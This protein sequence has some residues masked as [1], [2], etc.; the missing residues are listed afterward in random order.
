MNHR[1]R[2]LL[3]S[4]H[5]SVY[6]LA[7]LMALAIGYPAPAAENPTKKALTAEDYTRWRSINGAE[8]SGDGNW[9]AYTLQLTNTTPATAR[10]VLHILNLA[11]NEDVA[12]PHASGG[13]FSADSQWIAYQVDPNQGRNGRGANASEGE[14]QTPGDAPQADRGAAGR[15]QTPRRAEVRNLAS[16]ATQAFQD[17]QSFAFNAT[18]THLLLRRRPPTPPRPGGTTAPGAGAP[19]APPAP[20]GGGGPGG[21]SGEAQNTPRAADV[22]LLDLSTGRH[23][24]LGSVGD[25]AFNKTGD[26]LAYTVESAVKDGNGLFLVDTA[27]GRVATLDNDA[28]IYSRLTWSEDGTALAV[29]K[30]VEVEKMRERDNALIAFPDVAAAARGGSGGTKVPPSLLDTTAAGFPARW[31]ISDRAPLTWSEDHQRVFFGIKEQVPAPP[32]NARPNRDENAD[33]DVWNTA[34]ERVQSMQMIRAEQDRNFTF[35]QAFDVTGRR[36]VKLAD[37]TL[38]EIEIAKDGRWAIGRDTRGYVHD[39]KRPAADIYRVNTTTGERTLMLKGQMTGSHV[40]GISTDGRYFLYWKDH[41]FNAYDLDA[42]ASRT[43][44]NGSAVNF[45]DLEFDR[46]GPRPSYGIAGYT[47][48]GKGVIVNHRYDVWLLPLDGSAPQN[49]TNGAG[50]KHE[51]RFRYIRTER[52]D[53]PAGPGDGA[54]RPGGG[55]PNAPREPIDLTRPIT[56]SAYGEYTKKAGFYELANGQLKELL[57]EDASFNTP[58]KAARAERFLFTRQTFVEFPDL[59]VSGPGFA[60]AKKITDA[61]PQQ[62]EFLWGRRI[63]FDYR[64]KDGKRLQG[65]LALP[66]DY[67][68]GEKRP[69]IVTFYEKNSHNLHRYN[70]PNYLTGMGASPMEAVSRGYLTML[71]D[72]HF[73]TGSSHSDMLECVEAATRK[74]IE[75]GYADPKRIGVTGHSYGGEGAAFIGTQSR[76]FAAVAMGAGVTDLYSDFN[77]NWGWAYDVRGG[78]GANGHDYY[79]YG[80]GRWGFS[81]WDKPEVYINESALTHAPKVTAP[82]LIMHG[83][84]DPTVAFQNGLGFYNALRYNGKTAY[85]LAYPGEGHGLRGVA[86]RKDLTI[87]YFEFFDHYLKGAPAPKWMTDGVPFLKKGEKPAAPVKPTTSTTSGTER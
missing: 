53:T 3:R 35:R 64:N 21:E 71:P 39:Y 29:L 27:A 15:T 26:L 34:D 37:D 83:T 54:A 50:A 43:L 24:L 20:G 6:A 84:A 55:G 25:I 14:S 40:L 65:I 60:D 9:V 87:R 75:M 18:S 36:F 10:P 28:K 57:F 81:P 13:A 56:L 58:V 48:D 73:R 31:V 51:I 69:M 68:P 86:N 82:F 66:D 76:L 46:F 23:Q 85:L 4:R 78:S 12:I 5:Q 79:L 2:P 62:A 70:A 44:G 72:I 77:Q 1:S 47:S 19:A 16:G 8:I 22:I 38:R 11:T 30:G 67:K 49:L 32:A 74:V 61:N 59:R 63:L 7:L 42:G 45:T 33:V 17:I 52:A 80:Q 41:R